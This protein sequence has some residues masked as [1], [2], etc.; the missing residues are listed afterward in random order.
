MSGYYDVIIIGGG[1]EELR[2]KIAR[3]GHMGMVTNPEPV[4]AAVMALGCSLLELGCRVDFERI[5]DALEPD[6]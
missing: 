2:G 1:L 6:Q 4:R 3:I 5:L